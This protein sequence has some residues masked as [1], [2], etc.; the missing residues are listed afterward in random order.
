MWAIFEIIGRTGL[1]LKCNEM[2]EKMKICRGRTLLIEMAAM[3]GQ[4]FTHLEI[5]YQVIEHSHS[6]GVI[7]VLNVD[8]RPDF[9]RLFR[10]DEVR[11]TDENDGGNKRQRDG[12][13]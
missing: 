1:I 13:K 7:R 3:T 2:S 10:R 9:G 4:G 8:Q 6:I 11:F 12:S 5:L